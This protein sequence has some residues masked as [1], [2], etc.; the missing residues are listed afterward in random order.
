[1]AKGY[2]FQVDTDPHSMNNL[3]PDEFEEPALIGADYVECGEDADTTKNLAARIAKL[4]AVVEPVALGSTEDHATDGYKIAA[5]T[6]DQCAALKRAY[7][8][9]KLNVLKTRT[10]TL[11]LDEFCRDGDAILTLE[12]AINDR[13]GDGVM[14]ANELG[15]ASYKTFDNFIRALKPGVDYYLS[16]EYLLAH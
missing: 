15:Y 3:L 7:F 14:L 13:Y 1:M 5:M 8:E 9:A 11:T 4:G 2:I 12:N 10:Q 16:A 6:E